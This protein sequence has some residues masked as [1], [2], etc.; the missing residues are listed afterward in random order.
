[1]VSEIT[2][3]D[4]AEV[5]G[6]E[7][8][9]DFWTEGEMTAAEWFEEVV[10]LWGP[11]GLVLRRGEESLG[12]AVFGPPE[13]LPRVRRFRVGALS[14]DSAL[15]AYV[16]GDKRARRH[17]LA[18]V[19]R[20]LRL[21]GFG[22]VEAIG[23]DLGLRRRATIPSGFLLENGWKPVR[24][25]FAVPS[26]LP[27]TLFRADLGNTVEV[28]DLA[29]GLVDLVKLP[30]LKAP[31]PSLRPADPVPTRRSLAASGERPATGGGS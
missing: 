6:L 22:G 27:C 16:G 17:L 8:V 7:A 12:F 25:G 13:M 10:T 18:R 3:S 29:R 26:G 30:V 5:P 4:V 28:A 19:M 21:R 11:A 14:E 24:R 15:L 2:S 9:V 20:D 1:V 31:V 23:D